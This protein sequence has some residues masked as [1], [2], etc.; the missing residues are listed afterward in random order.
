MI[1]PEDAVSYVWAQIK[2]TEDKVFD[3]RVGWENLGTSAGDEP[4]Q[5]AA[6]REFASALAALILHHL[7]YV[8][9]E[10]KALTLSSLLGAVFEY[11]S[12]GQNKK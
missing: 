1:L 2:P 10:D 7:S 9:V 6:G 12:Y 3:V 11:V 8:P 5:E 4:T